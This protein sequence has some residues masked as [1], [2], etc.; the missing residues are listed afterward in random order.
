MACDG[1]LVSVDSQGETEQ[2]DWGA[3]GPGSG[4]PWENY[5]QKEGF[6]I[7]EKIHEQVWVF[8]S[9]N[10]GHC[11]IEKNRLKDVQHQR[12]FLGRFCIYRWL[13]RDQHLWMAGSNDEEGSK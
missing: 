13:E 1:V 2:K 8:I 9:Y 4:E 3:L 11:R 12:E 5:F 10:T 7:S 6:T